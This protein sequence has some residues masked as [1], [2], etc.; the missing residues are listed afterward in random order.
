MGRHPTIAGVPAPAY[1]SWETR[2]AYGARRDANSQDG[3][4]LKNNI[5]TFRSQQ[6][7]ARAAGCH[8]RAP[9]TASF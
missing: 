8:G 3:S 6:L 5:T 4:S 7:S 1:L 9:V 2:V